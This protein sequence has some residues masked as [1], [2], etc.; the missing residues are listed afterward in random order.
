MYPNRKIIYNYLTDV[1]NKEFNLKKPGISAAEIS[2]TFA[3]LFGC[4]PIFLQGVD[5]PQK[6][7]V[8]KKKKEIYF[9]KK[10]LWAD[11]VLDRTLS[12]V[13]KK[14]FEYYLKKM[15]FSRKLFNKLT[16]TSAFYLDINQSLKMFSWLANIANSKNIKIYNLSKNSSLRNVKL[17]SYLS[18]KKLEKDF[19]EYFK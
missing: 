10:N 3:L 11:Q 18:K 1:Y 17:I 15:D 12:V 19:N 14:S 13:R 6:Y 16:K 7:Y 9:G 4:N 8:G 2:L 5:I